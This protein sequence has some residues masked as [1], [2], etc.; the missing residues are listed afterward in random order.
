MPSGVKNITKQQVFNILHTD[1]HD[2]LDDISIHHQPHSPK[3]TSVLKP[4]TTWC[5]PQSNVSP[6]SA[7]R[8]EASAPRKSRPTT[9]QQAAFL[10]SEPETSHRAAQR[11]SAKNTSFHTPWRTPQTPTAPQRQTTRG[12]NCCFVTHI[13]NRNFDPSQPQNGPRS[14]N[15]L[16]SIP[17]CFSLS[18]TTVPQM[19]EKTK[20]K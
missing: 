13:P 1:T 17:L 3:I 7:W 10:N 20:K 4:L 19:V 11:H 5:D 9:K 16:I 15:N 14:P 2:R 8:P 18:S 6:W 12:K